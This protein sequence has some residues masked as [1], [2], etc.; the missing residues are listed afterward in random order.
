MGSKGSLPSRLPGFLEAPGAPFHPQGPRAEVA[1][2]GL[3]GH[4]PGYLFVPQQEREHRRSANG[5]QRGRSLAL[6]VPGPG[7]PALG[8]RRLS[9]WKL[10]NSCV[11]KTRVQTE[12]QSPESGLETGGLPPIRWLCFAFPLHMGRRICQERL[13]RLRLFSLEMRKLKNDLTTVFKLQ[14]LLLQGGNG[15]LFPS[16]IV[17]GE[18]SVGTRRKGRPLGPP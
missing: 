10:L 11:M 12:F 17:R 1:A 6:H 15:R 18:S 4:S 2:P 7:A 9:R 3:L 8:S 13:Q 16:D 5:A 14:R